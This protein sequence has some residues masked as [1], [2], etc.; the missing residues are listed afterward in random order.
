MHAADFNLHEEGAGFHCEH[1]KPIVSFEKPMQ[2][3]FGNNEDDVLTSTE[4][5][6]AEQRVRKDTSVRIS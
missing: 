2:T 1:E 5:H 3:A 4:P 6:F